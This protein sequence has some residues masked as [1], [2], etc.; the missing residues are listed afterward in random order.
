M[1]YSLTWLPDVLRKAG[2][3]V[4][5]VD[6]WQTRGRGDIGKIEFV[7]CHHTAAVDR[8]SNAPS[9]VIV[10]DGDA[11]LQGPRSQLVLGRD[12]A[13]YVVAAGKANHAG[14]G[15]WK[16]QVD[17]G[18]SKSI[19]IEAENNGL[20]QT[21]PKEGEPWPE[22]QM[23]AYAKGVAAILKHLGLGVDRCVAHKE[24][25][26]TRKIDPSFDMTKFRGSVGMFM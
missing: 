24:Y 3:K 11:T 25:A 6:G 15:S 23:I 18:N 16:G 22:V 5:E 19:G 1:I 17:V 7:L 20:I 4:I 2:L 26:P 14:K 9:L 10:R 12:G 13:Y 21:K 8:V